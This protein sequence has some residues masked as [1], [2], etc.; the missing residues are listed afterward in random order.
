[1]KL[2]NCPECG[3]LYELNVKRLCPDCIRKE[4]EDF[5]LIRDYL[6]QNPGAG[7]AEVSRVTGV[8]ERK[9]ISFL[10]AGRLIL[11]NSEH[12]PSLKCERCGR[13]ISDGRYC[14]ECSQVLGKMLSSFKTGE[15]GRAPKIDLDKGRRHLHTEHFQK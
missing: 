13:D 1:M 10:R 14:P 9:I 4:E 15:Q 11:K 2:A 6:R 7:I 8:A 3:R 12:S 5:A